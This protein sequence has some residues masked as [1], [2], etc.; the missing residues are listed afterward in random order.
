VTDSTHVATWGGLVFEV[1]SVSGRHCVVAKVGGDVGLSDS[2]RADEEHV[3]GSLEVAAGYQ[4]G[5][6][7][8]IDARNGGDLG[9]RRICLLL[10]GCPRYPPLWGSA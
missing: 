6:Q 9:N 3:R 2:G 8:P 10:F 4:R 7:V 5:E 1:G